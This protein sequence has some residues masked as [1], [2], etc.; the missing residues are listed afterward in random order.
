MMKRIMILLVFATFSAVLYGQEYE[1]VNVLS[2]T[3]YYYTEARTMDS[4]DTADMHKTIKQ[5]E[6]N[7]AVAIRVLNSNNHSPVVCTVFFKG[8]ETR[9]ALELTT[10]SV[11]CIHMPVKDLPRRGDVADFEI[12][13][14]R[15]GLYNGIAG[16]FDVYSTERVT[17]I[18]GK[19]GYETVTIKSE[20]PISPPQMMQLMDSLK[21]GIMP[22]KESGIS[23]DVRIVM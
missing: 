3:S 5:I 6:E 4:I 10:D 16:S 22:E 20:K 18:L 11:G 15:N 13:T 19:Q 8:S 9:S 23:I 7:E 12:K 17:I 21:R 2:E 14:I 1:V